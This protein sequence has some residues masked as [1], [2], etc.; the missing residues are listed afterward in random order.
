MCIFTAVIQAKAIHNKAR[1]ALRL[2]AS[3]CRGRK[4]MQKTLPGNPDDVRQCIYAGQ[5]FHVPAIAETRR[6]VADIYTA[7]EDTFGAPLQEVHARMGFEE[8]KLPLV[9]LRHDLEHAPRYVQ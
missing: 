6:L 1:A 4:M 8:M 3:L 2:R 7:L 9:K 5:I